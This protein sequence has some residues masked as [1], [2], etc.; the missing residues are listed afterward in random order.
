MN[1]SFE[2][3]RDDYE[4]SRKELNALHG[5]V[6][7]AGAAGARIAG[8]GFGGCLIAAV[9]KEKLEDFRQRLAADYF[10]QYLSALNDPV[11]PPGP[12]TEADLFPCRPIAGASAIELS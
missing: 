6:N 10:D 12:P 5:M 4:I 2:S 9:P 8:A 11:A 1:Q 7:Q 3:C